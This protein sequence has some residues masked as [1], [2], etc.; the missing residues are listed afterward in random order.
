M[1]VVA[2]NEEFSPQTVEYTVNLA[3]RMHYDLLAV[4]AIQPAHE[5]SFFGL[6][7]KEELKDNLKRRFNSLIDRARS[8][9]I[10]C[11]T[12]V[13]LKDFQSQIT[14]LLQ[15][16]RQIEFVL[17]QVSKEQQL[18]LNLGVPVYQIRTE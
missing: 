15:Q 3:E 13:T 12:F 10:H 9:R 4:N 14:Q 11:E 2:L 1:L 5:P 8:A 18:Y 17:I 7:K 16:I 6:G